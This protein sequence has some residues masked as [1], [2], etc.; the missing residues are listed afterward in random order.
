MLDWGR[1][2]DLR[3]EV[4]EED[5]F[6]VVDLFLDE[7][8]SVIDGLRNA[9]S[10]QTLAADLHFLKGSALN[11]GFDAVAELCDAG[12]RAIARYPG[13]EV[14]L[15]EISR[16]YAQSKETFLVAVRRR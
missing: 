16:V 3:T 11:L 7:V 12:H 14:D 15:A 6:E 8:D 10:P 9:S 4:G 2:E 5:F 1:I 13:A